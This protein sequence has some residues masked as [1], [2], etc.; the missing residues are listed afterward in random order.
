MDPGKTIELLFA[1]RSVWGTIE[2]QLLLRRATVLGGLLLLF[3]GLSPLGGQ[4]SLRALHKAN[5]YTSNST[6]LRYLHT[7]RSSAIYK[8]VLGYSMNSDQLYI[9]ALSTSKELK[10]APRDNLGN[11]RVPRL[12]LLVGPPPPTPRVAAWLPV[13]AITLP[14]QYASLLG[15]PVVGVPAGVASDFSLEVSYLALSCS[16]WDVFATAGRD[17]GWTKYFGQVWGKQGRNDSLLPF[18]RHNP[19]NKRMGYVDMSFFLDTDLPF[20]RSNATSHGQQQQRRRHLHFGSV[21]R[22]RNY[23]VGVSSCAVSAVYAEVAVHCPSGPSDCRAVRMRPSL[24]A[25]PPELFAPLEF[26]PTA[27]ELLTKLPLAAP[28]NEPG[29]NM[30][31][32]ESVLNDTLRLTFVGA[33]FAPTVNLTRLTAAELSSRLALVV[34][35]YYM[36]VMPGGGSRAFGEPPRNLSLFGYDYADELRGLQR[37]PTT[38]KTHRT[39][40]CPIFCSCVAR[41]ALTAVDEV[42]RTNAVWLALLFASAAAL[43]AAGLAGS[44]VSRKTLV[45]DMLGYVTSMTYDNPHLALTDHPGGKDADVI[46]A[47]ERARV[48]QDLPVQVGDICGAEDVG[49]IAFTSGANIRRLEMNRAYS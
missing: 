34:N 31:P 10:L 7:G 2:S 38:N 29:Y 5:R 18:R 8:P 20:G 4:A 47:M 11:V 33:E 9:T 43:L 14:E 15:I 17:G 36:S 49:H 46:D 45:P 42:Y 37:P 19:T 1:S 39:G 12:E 23:S 16:P 3:W 27:K 30:S 21:V 28:N 32:T 26:A 48:L 35:T 13:P 24:L 25:G 44:L 6:E 22:S 40:G 41:A